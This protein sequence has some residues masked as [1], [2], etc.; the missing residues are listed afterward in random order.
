MKTIILTKKSLLEYFKIKN[1]QELTAV[2][3]ASLLIKETVSARTHETF[4]IR[5]IELCSHDGKIWGIRFMG[6]SCYHT[7]NINSK[8]EDKTLGMITLFIKEE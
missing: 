5:Q 1:I 3:L 8:T 7:W 6:I 2:M 4:L